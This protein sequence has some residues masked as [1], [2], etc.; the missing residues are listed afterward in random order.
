M[1]TTYGQFV[2]CDKACLTCT[3][4]LKG[5]NTNCIKCN[6]NLGYFPI[7]GKGSAMC[8]NEET[9]GEGYFFNSFVEPNVWEE[10]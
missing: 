7:K 9:I 10:C 4:G 3:D 2:K 6:E 1:N 5:T 8:Y